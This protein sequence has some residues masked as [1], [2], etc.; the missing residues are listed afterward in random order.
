MAEVTERLLTIREVAEWLAISPETLY[1]WRHV[2]KGPRSL[3]VGGAVRY[4]ISDI[5]EWI[6]V[7]EGAG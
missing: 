7:K 5:E 4:R 3:K 2:H 1:Y 6:K